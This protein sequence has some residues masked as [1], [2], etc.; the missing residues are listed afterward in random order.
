[1]PQT[2][3]LR[4]N[5]CDHTYRMP[6]AISRNRLSRTGFRAEGAPVA[7]MNARL[8]ADTTKLAASASMATGAP[9]AW[10]SAPPMLGP[11]MFA[12]DSLAARALLPS[13]NR[14]GAP[15]R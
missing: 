2:A 14:W 3:T 11:A 8:A 5:R 10:I 12:A 1:M 6:A 4:A 15:R 9:T 7:H 13:T